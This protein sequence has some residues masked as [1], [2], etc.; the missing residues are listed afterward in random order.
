MAAGVP[1]RCIPGS[2]D[3]VNTEVQKNDHLLPGRK[4]LSA[5]KPGLYHEGGETPAT[6]TVMDFV[7]LDRI[8]RVVRAGD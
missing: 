8:E 7:S 6:S 4:P 1:H 2:M 5:L 3:P